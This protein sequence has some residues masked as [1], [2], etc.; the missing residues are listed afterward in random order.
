MGFTTKIKEKVLVYS[1]RHCCI[2]HK[3]CGL[4]LEVH[5]IKQQSE[6]G[7]DSFDNAIAV[8]FDC[9]AD[10][11]SY[12]Y[13]HPKGIKY[14]I[15]ELKNHRDNWYKKIKD[16][17][18]VANQQEIIETDKK[19]FEA[20][21]SIL[22]WEGSINFVRLVDF[23]NS[24]ETNSLNDFN[25]IIYRDKNPAFE[26]VDPDLEGLRID[27]ISKIKDLMGLIGFRTYPQS[28]RPEKNEVPKEWRE[29]KSQLYYEVVKLLNDSS[30]AVCES[31]DNL[32]KTAIRKLGI[33]PNSLNRV[34]RLFQISNSNMESIPYCPNCSTNE[35]KVS[36][37]PIPKAFVDFENA[38][39]ECSR[40]K[41]KGKY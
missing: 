28:H 9:H 34:E 15:S 35:N 12:D 38:N 33:I 40:C 27:L 17:I 1:G 11:R 14:T 16:N 2:C 18:G 6:G 29:T 5:H 4:K 32:I 20:F 37:S 3:F 8:C 30:A 31:Y 22:P 23:H 25:E 41:Y 26:F 21:V 19:V 39:Y 10:M 7:D 13:K 24:F 36:M